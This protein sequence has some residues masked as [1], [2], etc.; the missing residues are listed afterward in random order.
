M[1]SP[2]PITIV[3]GGLAGL[4]LGI[5]LRQRGIPAAVWEAGDYPRHRVCGEFISG[6]G[7]AVLQRLGLRTLLD[8]AGAVSL[9]SAAFVSGTNRSPVRQMPSPA[10]GL[11]RYRLDAT[12]AEE[13][14]RLGG[15]LHTGS[16]RNPF[17]VPADSSGAG[18]EAFSDGVVRAAGR[19]PQPTENGWRWF[20]LKA[21]ATNVD[22]AADLEMHISASH[23]IG[24]NRIDRGEVNICGL[25]RQ[26]AGEASEAGFDLLHGKPGTPLHE[27]LASARF[28]KTSLCSVAGLSLKPRRAADKTE[29]CIGD[30]ITM[31]PPVTGNGMS[32]AFESAEL[33][34][35]PLARYSRGEIAWA[36]ARETIAR[37]CDAA[38][39]ERLAWARRLQWL[40]FSSVLR[41]PVGKFL[42]NWDGIWNFLFTKTR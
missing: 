13:F 8:Q 24:V 27:R 14:Q 40:M 5:G 25:F 41:T 39:A 1:A 31:I 15:E 10:L 38:F 12:L 37:A 28:D 4:T 7:L 30:S 26:R 16:R 18:P 20:G 6:N 36:E 9:S 22:L 33:S 42:L 2:K 17:G 3:G 29:C 32:M 21:H 35:A 34:I 19:R 11:S 23:Y